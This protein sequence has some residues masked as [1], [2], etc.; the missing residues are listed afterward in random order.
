MFTDAEHDYPAADFVD[1][2]EEG[3][4]GFPAHGRDLLACQPGGDGGDS[5][6][7]SPEAGSS[8]SR[9]AQA[10][11]SAEGR[12]FVAEFYRAELAQGFC[13]FGVAGGRDCRW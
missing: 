3:G 6:F 12:V 10:R 1:S 11:S 7:A 8:S 2:L 5:Q 13:Q 9:R 4:F